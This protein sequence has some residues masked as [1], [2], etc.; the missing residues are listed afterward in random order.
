MFK[1][2]INKNLNKLVSSKI[3]GIYYQINSIEILSRV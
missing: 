2:Q 1:Y 3:N